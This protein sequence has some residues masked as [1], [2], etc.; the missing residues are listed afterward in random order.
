M[1]YTDVDKSS[2]HFNT[3]LYTGNN[4]SNSITGVGFQPDMTWIKNRTS[5]NS[6]MLFDAI[7]GATY[8]LSTDTN[9]TSAAYSNSLTSFDSDG[10]TLNNFGD[11]NA[12]SDN[13]VA[14]NFKANGQGSSNAD[15]SIT[16]T[17]TS[18]NTTSGF[19]MVKFTATGSAAT[20]GHGLGV[21]PA[22]ILV[23]RTS[24]TAD[25]QVYHKSLGATKY[26]E[27]SQSQAVGTAT[28]RWNDTE[29]T[30]SVFSIGNEWNNGSELMAYCFAEKRGFSKFLKYQANG[31]STNMFLN[32]G[33]KPALVIIKKESGADNWIMF[34]N[35]RD[36]DNVVGQYLFPNEANAEASGTYMDFVSNGINIRTSDGW[37]NNASHTYVMLA[38]AEAP[39]VGTNNVPCTAR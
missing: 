27:F 35:K 10:F 28:N 1:A 2:L 24:S 22:F 9:E 4:S 39:L 17:Y 20:V 26:L 14:W 37:V 16:T 3:K 30:S 29:P 19:S 23:K 21:A 8:R 13:F 15:G 36:T 12:N 18:A 31:Q 32:C 11:V 25:W 6:H 7:R 5:A 34:D 33:F 38:F